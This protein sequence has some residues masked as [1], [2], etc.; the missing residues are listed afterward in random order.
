MR[1]SHELTPEQFGALLNEYQRLLRKLFE[2]MGGRG[3]ELSGDSAVAT[4]PTTKQAALAAAAAQRAVARHEWSHGLRLAISVGLHSG[5]AP[6]DWVSPVAL[7][8]SELC[9]AADG[10]QIFMSPVTASLLQ[11]ED[12]GDLLL[13]DLGEQR[14]RRTQRALRVYELVVPPVAET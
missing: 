2:G 9:D 14:T 4:F 8:C 12:L 6:T 1:L 3:V 5:Q 13:R 11:D 10:G 7:R